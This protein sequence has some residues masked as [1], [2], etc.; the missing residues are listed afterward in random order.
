[1]VDGLGT[2]PNSL[3]ASVF[4]FLQGS[5][6]LDL[7]ACD[8]ERQVVRPPGSYQLLVKKNREERREG[9]ALVRI[10]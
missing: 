9:D 8:I 2:S 3:F 7:E 5:Q 6:D 4:F 1:M 10:V